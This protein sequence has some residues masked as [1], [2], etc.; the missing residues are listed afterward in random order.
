[1]RYVPIV[2]KERK[3]GRRG[4]EEYICK[5]CG[6]P[7]RLR[8]GVKDVV[9]DYCGFIQTIDQESIQEAEEDRKLQIYETVLAENTKT[10]IWVERAKRLI[11]EVNQEYAA[12]KNERAGLDRFHEILEYIVESGD[13]SGYI[14]LIVY[15]VHSKHPLS[16]AEGTVYKVVVSDPHGRMAEKFVYDTK[17][18]FGMMICKRDTPFV[19]ILEYPFSDPEC[20]KAPMQ[21]EEVSIYTDG[22]KIPVVE[23]KE[24]ALR[25]EVIVDYLWQ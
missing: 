24:K 22:T 4:M 19:K 3:D 25:H 20:Q 16:V 2:F 1:M 9:C 13:D 23:I 12:S 15:I 7:I 11:D 18:P 8:K 21:E 17:K 14:P 6:A 5:S 10:A